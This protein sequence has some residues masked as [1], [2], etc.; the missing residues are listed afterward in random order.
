MLLGLLGSMAMSVIER[1]PPAAVATVN[2]VNVTEPA[3]PAAFVERKRPR[4]GR[5]LNGLPLRPP[6]PEVVETKIVFGSAG[7]TRIWEIARPVITSLLKLSLLRG[8]TS[9]GLVSALSMRY[10]PTPKKLSREKFASP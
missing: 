9:T 7:C 5:I 8:P 1:L 4:D 6:M 3:G 10:T 2:F